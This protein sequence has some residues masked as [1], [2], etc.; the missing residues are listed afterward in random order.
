MPRS[1]QSGWMG[2]IRARSHG[3]VHG[4]RLAPFPARLTR[5]VADS[6]PCLSITSQ[7]K[8]LYLGCHAHSSTQSLGPYFHA[9]YRESLSVLPFPFKFTSGSSRLLL[10]LFS[11]FTFLF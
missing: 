3:R 8:H 7:F 5:V 10:S 1:S 4:I 2:I 11:S 6:R 9:L